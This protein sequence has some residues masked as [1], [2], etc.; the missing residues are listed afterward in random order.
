MGESLVQGLLGSGWAEPSQVAVTEVAE[1]RRAELGSPEG[2]A[3][4][5][6]GMRL[7]DGELPNAKGVV[8]AVKPAD[9]EVACRRLAG[10]G[11]RRLLSIA[12]GVTLA[13]LESWAPAGCAVGRAMPNM[14]TLVQ[15]GA[16][17]VCGGT[18]AGPDDLEWAGGIM[19]SVGLVV[20]VPERLMD[21]VTG[22]SGSGPA[23]LFLVVEAMVEAGVLLGL[24][25]GVAEDLV[26]QTLVGS[27]RLLA[28]TG[29]GPE[30]LRA[31]VTSP[32]GTTAAGLRQLEAAGTRSAFIEA[33]AAAVQRSR[34]LGGH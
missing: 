26:R 9:V 1:G 16:T 30:A 12:A 18:R 19:R 6:P 13:D 11:V 25:R 31:A 33:V 5:Y 27:G 34:E 20:E 29:Q 14:G 32:G 22:L 24:P 8:V 15:A 28:E 2:L 4:R 21:T 17:A 10:H 7:L 3:G 23:Y